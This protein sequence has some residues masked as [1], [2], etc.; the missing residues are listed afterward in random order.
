MR[1]CLFYLFMLLTAG[2]SAQTTVLHGTVRAAVS[3]EVLVGANVWLFG[4]FDGATTDTAGRFQFNTDE[5][6]ARTLLILYLGCDTFRQTLALA[7]GKIEILAQLRESAPNLREVV[8]SAGAFEAASDRRRATVLSPVDIALTASA[9]A[10]IAGA[11]ATLPGA[12]RNGE[13]GQLLVRGGAAYET[14]TFIDGLYVQ[15]PY[16]SSVPNVPARN[17][18]SPFMFKG[19]QFATGAYSAEY[20]QALS[21]ALLLHTDDLAPETTTGLSL[22]SVGAGAAHTRRWERTSLAVSADY[23]NLAPYFALV[24]QNIRW[25]TPPQSAGAELNLRRQ[26]AG[27]G[28]FKLYANANRSW[29]RMDYPD[30]FSPA[31]THPLRLDAHN[32]YLNT[33]YRGAWREKWT[34][35]AG[36]AATI[37][38]DRIQ[39]DFQ[40]DERQYSAQARFT[41]ARDLGRRARLKWGGEYLHG[42]WNEGYADTEARRFHTRLP[43]RYAAAFAETDLLPTAKLVLRTGLRAEY[44]GLLGRANLAPRLSAAWLL[45][46][47][48][49]IAAAWGVFYQTPEHELMR[50]NTNLHYEQALHYSLN[51]QRIRDGHTFRI[52]AY[53]KQYDQ[54][55]KTAADGRSNNRGGGYARGVDLFWR[56]RQSIRNGDFW[57]A[58]SFL[59]TRRDHRDFPHPAVPHFAAAHNASL[60]YKHWFPR[61]NT[62]FGA[63]YAFQSG[64][65][66]HDPNAA[67]AFNTGRTPAY[68]DISVNAAYLTNLGGHFTILYAS[69][70]NLPGFRQVH[71]Y[72]FAALPGPDGRFASRA[73]I[74]PAKRFLFIGLFINFGKRYKQGEM[75]GEEL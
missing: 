33:S 69:V 11:L 68:H 16:N 57:V 46:D 15:N 28:M 9:T 1:S 20:G 34:L 10:D 50:R 5:T 7:G 27:D 44:S 47:N 12:V 29:M 25:H 6:G 66:Y 39:S 26:T 19:V 55:V 70:T 61:W 30:A 58:Y 51:Y 63:T 32:L 56:D 3:G 24:R 48:E 42:A 18:F 8:I 21:S 38:R 2:A 36:A 54:L 59:D 52:E 75:T 72:Q 71:G 49:Q 60:V 45:G 23:S 31:E 73:I 74:P 37:N 40:L 35:F 67:P 17:R 62:A 14:R 53:W 41:L 22:M 43:E 65:P 4:T 64:R 13:S